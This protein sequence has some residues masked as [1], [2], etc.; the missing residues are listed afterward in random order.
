MSQIKNIYCQILSPQAPCYSGLLFQLPEET[1]FL[2]ELQQGKL[3]QNLLKE[4]HEAGIAFSGQVYPAFKK[5]HWLLRE[6]GKEFLLKRWRGQL[7]L[8]QGV[9][10]IVVPAYDGEMAIYKGH[11]NLVAQLLSGECRIQKGE[12]T[13][14]YFVNGGIAKV[15]TSGKNETLLTEVTL[16]VDEA[17]TP[18]QIQNLDEKSIQ[19]E[20]EEAKK[21]K[22]LDERGREKKNHNIHA[23]KSKLKLYQKLTAKNS[24]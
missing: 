13:L 4:F 24:S 7:C 11:C 1:Q 9:N 6:E 14:F 18:E 17:L 15:L 5:D 8:Y 16:L 20:L 3:P 22:A 21:A 2:Q 19:N 10:S 23:T 12:E